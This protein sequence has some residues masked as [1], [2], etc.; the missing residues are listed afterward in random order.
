[1]NKYTLLIIY[2][3]VSSTLIYSQDADTT[4]YKGDYSFVVDSIQIFGNETTKDEIIFKEI[5]C[6]IGDTVNSKLL[7]YNKERI[8]S[9]GLFTSVRVIPYKIKNKNIIAFK[10]EE[11]WY[12][13]PIPFLQLKDRDW[14][15][16][17]YGLALLMYNFR[18]RNETLAFKG[19]LGYDPSLQLSYKNPYLNLDKNISFTFNLNLQK[20]RSK[21]N[22]AK[23]LAGF[24]FDQKVYSVNVTVGKRFDIYNNASVSA[25]FNSI[26]TPFYIR[27]ISASD[28]RVD[29]LFSLAF[30]YTFDN[31][32]LHQF[33]SEGFFVSSLLQLK[34]L[35]IDGIS[36][37]VF[38]FDVRKY[39]KLNES[40]ILKSRF[41]TRQTF[42]DLI[43]YYDNS[44]LGFAER[45]RGHFKEELE[46]NNSYI[47][48]VEL[49]YALLKDINLSLDFIPIIPKSLLNY[50][51]AIY[52]QLFAD[53]GTIQNKNEPLSLKKLNSGYGIGL[54]LLLLPY[55]VLRFER[56]WDEYGNP[57]WIFDVGVS[58]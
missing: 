1:M 48:S 18:G 57:E 44:F 54:T 35:G 19:A 41:A 16:L 40:F 33:P 8:Y 11:S 46:G 37:Q 10:V 22:I 12:L 13:Y 30:N 14:K 53:T 32:D 9:L 43:P 15:K 5:T 34:G 51:F 38:N 56:A 39:F 31:R 45:I 58:F 28:N 26:E 52:L 21:S 49:D 17:S 2:L 29:N 50:R 6:N 25:S 27:G 3:F 4:F 20:V 55:H 24:D 42:G 7:K 47:G 23:R 36:Y